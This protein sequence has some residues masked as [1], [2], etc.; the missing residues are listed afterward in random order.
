MKM[1]TIYVYMTNS[2]NEFQCDDKTIVNIRIPLLY[3][4]GVQTDCVLY[5]DGFFELKQHF[6]KDT[7]HN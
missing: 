5:K 4:L 3:T 6:C 1:H 2:Y 7:L